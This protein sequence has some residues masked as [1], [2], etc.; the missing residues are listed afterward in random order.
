MTTACQVPTINTDDLILREYRETDFEAF[1]AFGASERARFVGGPQDRWSSW[2]SFM[3]GIGHWTLRGYGMWM[4]EHRQTG[5]VAGRVGM[6]FNDSWDEPELGWHIY[7]GFE[8]KGYAFQA[9]HAARA[10]SAEHFGLDAV[11]SYID[12]ENTRSVALARRLGAQFEREGRLLGTPCHIYRHPR[13]VR[14]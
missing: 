14:R 1:A 13:E 4:V 12:P 5:R 7:D 11:I 2:R 6:I 8:G 9:T 10:Y 3:A